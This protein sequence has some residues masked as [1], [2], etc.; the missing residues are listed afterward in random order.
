MQINE[1]LVDSHL[2]AIE[3]VGAWSEVAG[4]RVRCLG[5]RVRGF[6]RG[7]WM[8]NC[9]VLRSPRKEVSPLQSFSEE[10]VRNA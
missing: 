8:L 3:G 6:Q 1:A 9:Y 5:L 4:F 2:P 10:K 7:F